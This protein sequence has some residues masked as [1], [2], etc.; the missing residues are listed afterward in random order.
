MKEQT[1]YYTNWSYNAAR[2]LERLSHVIENNGGYIAETNAP[3][4]F[5]HSF[6]TLYTI[7]NRT[8]AGAIREKKSFVNRLKELGRDAT[9]AENEL[10][11][12]QAIQAPPII[13]RFT[14]GIHFVIDGVYYELS[15]NDNPF[16]PFHYRKIQLK[17]NKFTGEFYSE[18]FTKDWLYDCL[19]SFRC[20]NDEIKE[21]ANLIFN[22][23]QSAPVSGEYIE[24]KKE[25]VPNRYNDGYHYETIVKRNTK[26]TT[27]YEVEALTNDSTI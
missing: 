5:Y 21:I 19:F 14:T 2:L 23:L 13:T 4:Y 25:R 8:L 9:N 17:N 6:Q 22:A 24:R 27:I 3:D 20:N 18:E 16:F 15:F 12:L 7:H 26:T 1:Y 10:Q 11:E